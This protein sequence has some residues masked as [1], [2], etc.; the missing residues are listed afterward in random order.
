[1][2]F[3]SFFYSHQYTLWTGSII[4]VRTWKQKNIENVRTS[5]ICNFNLSISYILRF[6]RFFHSF[7]SCWNTRC[8]N[9]NQYI[10][11]IPF[12]INGEGGEEHFH[13]VAK[14]ERKMAAG[15]I[16]SRSGASEPLKVNVSGMRNLFFLLPWKQLSTG[17]RSLREPLFVY[18]TPRREAQ[19][20]FIEIPRATLLPP[21]G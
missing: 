16:K 1:M 3:L 8:K 12:L 7:H 19:R 15:F 10:R 21:N 5:E 13:L 11:L 9:A 2:W 4:S 6:L 18:I 20:I 17:K 14:S